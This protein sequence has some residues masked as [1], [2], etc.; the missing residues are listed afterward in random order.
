MYSSMRFILLIYGV[1]W[2][3]IVITGIC[4]KW[5]PTIST[6]YRSTIGIIIT[7]LPHDCHSVSSHPQF[8]SSFKSFV[9]VIKKR[10]QRAPHEWPIVRE[11]HRW[12]VDSLTKV[13]ISKSDSMLSWIRCIGCEMHVIC[14]VLA[15]NFSFVISTWEGQLASSSIFIMGRDPKYRAFLQNPMY[16]IYSHQIMCNIIWFQ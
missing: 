15:I 13:S 11:I 12:L 10:K 7:V 1:T 5:H 6:G 14:V 9:T 16:R 3:M 8:G 2:V 4:R